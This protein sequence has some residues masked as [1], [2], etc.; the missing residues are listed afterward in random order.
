MPNATDRAH[1]ANSAEALYW[2]LAEHTTD[3][4]VRAGMDG[5]LLY[6]SPSCR[7]LGYSPEDLI[8]RPFAPLVHPDDQ[9]RFAANNAA[10]FSGEPIDR[11]GDRVIRYRAKDGQ[12]IW[13][14]GNPQL[15]R[16]E[17]GRPIEILN[18]LRNVTERKRAELALEQAHARERRQADR[19]ALAIDAAEV[20]IWEWDMVA[21][22]L[23]WDARMYELYGWPADE[24]PPSYALFEA[25]LHPDDRERVLS[26][27]RAALAGEADFDT[28]F[29]IIAR[30]GAIR[31]LRARA[32]MVRGPDGAPVSVVGVN[33]DITATRT[34]EASLRASKTRM[35][36]VIDNANEAIVSFDQTGLVIG[37]NR[38]AEIIFGWTAAEALG[39][40]IAALIIPPRD[41]PA[42]RERLAGFL[43]RSDG[44]ILDQRLELTALRKTGEEFSIEL[45][46]SA[47]A[48]QAGWEITALMHDISARRAG[49]SALAEAE[50]RYRLLAENASDMISL[51][52]ADGRCLY[53]SPSSL[54]MLGYPADELIGTT[55]LDL[56]PPEEHAA[57]LHTRARLIAAPEGVPVELLTRMRRKDGS[58]VWVEVHARLA[59]IEGG[60]VVVAVTRDVSARV[61][62]DAEL[63]AARDAAEAGAA[64]K[65]DFMA[66]MS[67]EIRTPLTAILGFTKLLSSRD[68]LEA[69]AA[70]HV[71]RIAGASQ[72]LLSIVNDILDFSKLEAGQVEIA[73]R[74]V[75]PA[76]VLRQSLLLFSPQADAKGLALRFAEGNLPD[77]VQ[78]DPDRLRQVLLN[79]I[80]NAVKFTETGGV[81][82][83]AAYDDDAQQLSV[84][85]EDTGPGLGDAE[86]HKL[87]Q[88]F[89]QV[90]ASSTRRHGGTGLGLA[91]C[92]GLV[93]AM[94]GEIGVSSIPGEGSCFFFSLHAPRAAAVGRPDRDTAAA[95]S[96][97][98]VRV[99]VV[100]DNPMNRELARAILGQ[101]GAEVSEAADGLAAVEAAQALPY[102]VILLDIR[103][104]GLDG[105]ATLARIREEPGPNQDV[106]ILAF[107]A[108]AGL[109]HF[110]AHGFDDVVSKP[111][112]AGA[113]VAAVARAVHWDHEDLEVADARVA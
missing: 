82:L 59:E 86:Q 78:I 19:M 26:E 46:A 71:Q 18:A 32:R 57:L 17:V 43:G 5:A 37:W 63:R 72:A 100:D 41:H 29:R 11:A 20:G 102:D 55:M 58:Y 16:D 95:T 93:E 70:T 90:D 87:F 69:A 67:H 1:P 79:L 39:N 61:L 10:L 51:Q 2:L 23:V 104:P 27:R 45:A 108:D 60:R 74:P 13:L 14:E 35:R 47:I 96:L 92:K 53:M 28:D 65:S 111:L 105:P 64:A 91:I 36:N 49:E 75:D 97:D 94:G 21:G 24:A 101:M 81:R 3:I 80:G 54:Q 9:A 52:G 8:G 83:A 33:W 73:S 56:T 40:S 15:I 99:L 103:M 50:A 6:V 22:A 12:W 89:S 25:A 84:R 109:E 88:R 48:G 30:G 85:I 7:A 98:G 107:S 31:H 44:T 34:L 77:C 4:I 76:E 68:D 62:Q 110:A 106:P 38:H 113:L 112:E 42:L 66:N